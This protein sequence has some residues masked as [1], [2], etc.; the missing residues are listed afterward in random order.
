MM[1]IERLFILLAALLA[2]TACAT[3]PVMETRGVN[4][5]LTP[6]LAASDMQAA[7]GTRVQ[8]G[9]TIV[10]SRNLQHS[11]QLE[12]LAYPLDASGKPKPGA[13]PLGRFVALWS[14][15][16][17]TV[18]YAPGRWVTVVG[19][20]TGTHTGRVGKVAYVY[21]VVRANQL[22]L[23]PKRRGWNTGPSVNFGVGVFIGN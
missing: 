12:I 13:G 2:L 19:P 7:R 21:P 8:W 4:Y 18:D 17:E 16:L 20:I 15:Y 11:T 1:R 22:H 3:T 5:S 10:G 14:G 6:V 9:G 23:W